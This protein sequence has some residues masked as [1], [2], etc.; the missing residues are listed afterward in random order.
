MTKITTVSKKMLSL[1]MALLMIGS[2]VAFSASAADEGAPAKPVCTL[3]AENRTITVKEPADGAEITIEPADKAQRALADNGKDIL[4]FNLVYGTEYVITATLNEKTSTETVKLLKTQAVPS[5]PV[6]EKRTATTLKISKVAGCEYK[7]EGPDEEGNTVIISD[8]GDTVL[9]ENLKPETFYVIYARKAAVKDEY[10]AS[11]AV[12]LSVKTL[13]AG[14]AVAVAKPV[15][16]DKTNTTI[17]VKAEAGVEYSIDGGKTWQT[18][19]DFKNL[20]ASTSYTIVAREAFDASVQ[21]ANP[22][23]EGLTVITNSRASYEA[24]LTRCTFKAQDGKRYANENVK[25][26]VTGD[27]PADLNTVQYGDTMYAPASFEAAGT[28]ADF[29]GTTKV[30]TGTFLPGEANADKTVVVTVT[31]N[32]LKYVGNG[33][34]PAGTVTEKYTVKI[35]PVNNTLTKIKEGLETVLNFLLN[36]VPKFIS[37]ALKSDIWGKIG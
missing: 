8:W 21:E 6:C 5:A 29:A 32:K 31:Y 2:A 30:G 16:E 35:G 14:N 28:K 23:S 26:T 27:A 24:S 19:G 1:I 18:S 11:D 10:Y 7:A 15:L 34:A 20:K 13:K 3:N 17:T 9:F 25:I 4:F 12:S 33:W 37:D 22:T 36:T